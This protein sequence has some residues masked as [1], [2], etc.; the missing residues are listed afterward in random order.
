MRI[1]IAYPLK[2]L[3]AKTQTSLQSTQDICS[4]LPV[5]VRFIVV[6]FFTFRDQPERLH[7]AEKTCEPQKEGYATVQMTPQRPFVRALCTCSSI[8]RG[9]GVYIDY[10]LTS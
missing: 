8:C 10:N 3:S 7:S 2:L 4:G 5:G 9:V 1:A 6:E